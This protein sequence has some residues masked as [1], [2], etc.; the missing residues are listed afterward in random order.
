MAWKVQSIRT[1]KAEIFIHW[2]DRVLIQIS[3]SLAC[4]IMLPLPTEVGVEVIG[5][6]RRTETQ[7]KPIFCALIGADLMVLEVFRS[8][9]C[10]PGDIR[11]I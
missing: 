5:L 2:L 10:F 11:R 8:S 1:K 7:I 6:H 9:H 4:T 3:Y